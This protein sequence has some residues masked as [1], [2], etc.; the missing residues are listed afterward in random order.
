MNSFNPC[1]ICP[2]KCNKN[3]KNS[4]GFCKIK[5]QIKVAR[6]D[7]YFYEEPSISGTKGSGTIFFSGCNLDCVYCQN[8]EIVYILFL[9]Y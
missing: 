2:R 6:C 4:L 5:D 3:R 9:I 8:H 7:L 1:N